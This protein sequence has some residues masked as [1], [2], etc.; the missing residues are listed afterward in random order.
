[1]E[2]DVLYNRIM[3]QVLEEYG[4][5][6]E[7]IRSISAVYTQGGTVYDTDS[8]DSLKT[9][10]VVTATYNNSTT[11]TVPGTDYTLSGTLEAGTSTITVS[12]SGK[13][14][15]FNVNVTEAVELVSISAVYTQGGTVY[16]TDSLDSLKDDLVVTATY[17]NSTTETVPGTDYT[18]SGTLEVGTSTIT[19]AYG[20]KT[21]T[22]S[23]NVTQFFLWE[24]TDGYTVVKSTY[25]PAA[26]YTYRKST[27]AR[28]CGHD[29]IVN[30]NYVFTVTDSEKYN[31]AAY[32]VTSLE[33]H[34]ISSTDTV[35]GYG[36]PNA[37][38]TP[39]WVTS[40]SVSSEYV[41]LTL[42]KM[43]NTA[44]TA[45]ELANGAEAVFTYTES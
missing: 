30:N 8:L 24:F 27:A 38:K 1:M 7:R 28:A 41:W 11:E 40:D 9:D 44:F 32:G 3:N 39:S 5:P 14:T 25:G 26:G 36:Y 16:D 6:G 35:D 33:K 15:T 37:N 17:S 43:D 31:L 2:N 23:V 13:T 20:G 22:F 34:N 12:Y 42:K 10:L 29:P 18:L 19:V 45:E 21:T 4:A